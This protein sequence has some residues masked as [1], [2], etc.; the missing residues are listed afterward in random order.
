MAVATFVPRNREFGIISRR[1]RGFT[2]IELLVV[3]AIIAVLVAVL[4]PALNAARESAR[5]VVVSD[6]FAWWQPCP[7]D[8]AIRGG[9]HDRRGMN[10]VRVDA[11]VV[12]VPYEATVG[13]YPY[14]WDYLERF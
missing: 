3:V 7:W 12:W 10:V 2:L 11:S 1:S 6:A 8:Q 14:A 13:T 9:N 4:L 5:K